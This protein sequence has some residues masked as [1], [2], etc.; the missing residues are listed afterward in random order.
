M[1]VKSGTFGTFGTF[2]SIYAGRYMFQAKVQSGTFEVSTGTFGTFGPFKVPV[3]L[4]KSAKSNLKLAT[5]TSV[6]PSKNLSSL[7]QGLHS[8]T[9]LTHYQ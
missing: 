4:P 9:L 3:S 1:P 5:G 6:G 7:R 2:A 8:K